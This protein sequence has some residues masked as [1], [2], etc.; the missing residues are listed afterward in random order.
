[1]NYKIVPL[2]V[3]LSV[4]LFGDLYAQIQ[5][6]GKVIDSKARETVPYVNIGIV[7]LGIGTV[8]S[9]EGEFSLSNKA[10]TPGDSVMFSAV[11][12]ETNYVLV[13]DILSGGTVYLTPKIFEFDEITV[14][15]KKLGRSK[16]YGHKI[17]R[18]GGD[19]GFVEGEPGDEMAGIIEIK[20]PTY[21]ESAHFIVNKVCGDSM[22]YRVNIYDFKDGI[23]G[24][25]L[26]TK[27]TLISGKQEVGTISV[28]IADQNIVLENDV[29]LALEF[30]EVDN[31]YYANDCK[32]MRFRYN[33]TKQGNYLMRY[34]EN[35]KNV[36]GPFT[37]ALRV[38]VG[39]Y[40]RGRKLR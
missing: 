20:R 9:V 26:L 11:G 35:S 25:N 17:K 30:I 3:L 36:D 14:S 28:D 12:Y 23:L 1:M 6:E 13:K 8:S 33:G 19:L 5:F 7:R 40:F 16:V 32:G 10:I 2:M 37:R 27:N 39:F 31:T 29:L 15:A 34:V 22:V 21:I 24:E 18:F 38:N 4:L